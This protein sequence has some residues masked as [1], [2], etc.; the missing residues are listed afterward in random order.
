MKQ[1]HAHIK[2]PKDLWREF[3]I[4][5]RITQTTAS[6]EIRNFVRKTLG[7]KDLED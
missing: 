4:H 2:F 1:T 3:H 7:K 6:R 5:C